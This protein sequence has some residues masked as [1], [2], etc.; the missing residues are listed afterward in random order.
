MERL[1]AF[2]KKHR[3]WLGGLCCALAAAF[4]LAWAGYT[5]HQAGKNQSEYKIVHDEY[6]EKQGLYPTDPAA[7]LVQ[8]LPAG[9]GKTLYGVRLMFVTGGRVAQGAFR[10]ALES[11][12]GQT[13]TACDGDM[14]MLLDGAFVDVIFASPVTL[15]EGGS[16]QLR[17][18][19]APA[20]AEDKAGLVY[21][22]G[23]QA[24][25]AMPLTDAAEASAPGRTA[26]LQYITNYTGTGYALRAFAPLAALV[27]LAVMVGWWLIFVRRA[28][29]HVCFAFFAA[30]LGLVFALV[31]PP[32]AGPDEYGHLASAYAL[33]N[34][35][36]GQPGITEGPDGE[37]LLAMRECDAEYMRDSS[38]P[39]G[40]LAYKTMTDEL[41]STGNSGELTASAQV[42]PPYSVVAL[43]YL[44]QALG[45]LLARALGLG[46]HAM[47][48]LA[49]PGWAALRCLPRWARWRCALPRP[50]RTSFSRRAFCPWP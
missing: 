15:E 41:F 18:T 20:A 24:A 33:A 43:Q 17:V 11:A 44:P 46:F 13:L 49:R 45:I 42:S 31:T 32:L 29:A 40:I 12:D 2:I 3:L 35:I 5:L 9:E 39:I 16:Y 19:F 27:F 34:R 21:G 30:A 7:G 6:V 22:E 37:S 25:P 1:G 8:G 48:L 4:A 36:T 23:E 26:A 28:K 47:L 38:G 10:V 14:T 50:A